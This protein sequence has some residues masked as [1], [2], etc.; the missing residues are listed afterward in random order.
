MGF[1]GKWLVKTQRQKNKNAPSKWNS[2]HCE[3]NTDESRK[4]AWLQCFH[5]QEIPHLNKFDDIIWYR[6]KL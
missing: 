5:G 3:K 6:T 4:I 1:Y 2:P